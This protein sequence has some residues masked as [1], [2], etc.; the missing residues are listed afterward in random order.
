MW[1]PTIILPVMCILALLQTVSFPF[2]TPE[3]TGFL[4]L[5]LHVGPELRCS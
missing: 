5:S 3:L 1:K 2:T 4:P